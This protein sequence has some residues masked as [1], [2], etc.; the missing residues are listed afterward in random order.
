MATQRSEEGRVDPARHVAPDGRVDVLTLMAEIR[1]RV[2]S[3]LAQLQDQPALFKSEAADFNSSQRKAGEL[4]GSEELRYLNVNHSFPLQINHGSVTTHRGGAVG[5]AIVAFKRK[6]RAFLLNRLFADYLHA[7]RDY[8]ASLVRFLNDVSKYVDARDASNFWELIRKIDVD[9][10]KA[11]ERVERLAD[12]CNATS[13]GVERKVGERLAKMQGSLDAQAVEIAALKSLNSVVLG[14]EGIIA[15]LSERAPAQDAAQSGTLPDYSYLLLE[16]RF[17]GSEEEVARGVSIYP[18][19]FK[20]QSKPVL[21]IGCGRGELLELFKASGVDAYGV[22]LDRGMLEIAQRKELDARHADALA[23]L[24]EL[25]AGSLGGVIA[26]QVV[27]HLPNQVLKELIALCASRVA[28][29]GRVIFETINP[30]SL[31]ALSSNYFRDPT[32]VWPLHPDTLSY[33]ISLGGLEVK[34]TR[35]LS[36]VPEAAKF[37]PIVQDEFMSPRWAHVVERINYNFEQLNELMYGCQ[38][39]CV[40]AQVN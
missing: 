27:E 3:E 12:E 40:I 37:Q 1:T 7:Q 36:P 19:L 8:N 13:L 14:L 15:R 25:E 23:H 6:L 2:K 16:N 20:S 21:E 26:V 35:F 4:L 32:H 39:Y 28:S 18:P 10:G 34:E 33:L 38:D 22:D 31:T 11:M 30:R 5:R 24:R 9:T 17:R 29:G